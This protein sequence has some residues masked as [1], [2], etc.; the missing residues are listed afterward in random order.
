[1][2]FGIIPIFCDILDNGN[3]SP[4]A[5]S[6]SITP[7]TKAL[8]VTHMWGMPCNMRAIWDILQNHPNVLLIEDCSHAHGA[9]IDGQLVGTF[10]DAAAWSLQGQKIIS[11]GEG[12]ITLTKNAELYYRQLIWGHY[13][14]RCKAEI[15]SDH[16]LSS[17][18]LTG[19]GAKN[20]AHPLAIA[21]AF[22]QLERLD[23]I[24]QFKALY[25]FQMASRL[26]SIPFLHAPSMVMLSESQIEPAWYALVFRF[27]ASRAPNGLSRESFVRKL[28]ERGLCEVDIPKSTGLLHQEPLYTS[29]QKLFPHLYPHGIPPAYRRN[30]DFPAAQAFYDEAIKLPVW[31]SHSD[32]AVVNHYLDVIYDV[33]RVEISNSNEIN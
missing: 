21:L 33:A 16:P 8:V 22:T 9:K 17:F 12:G 3:I 28:H 26:A 32:Q 31:T 13:N 25:A 4:E 19:A 30:A 23:S 18:S 15:P 7:R 1:M 6:A 2:Q 24:I 20:R 5:I 29:P 10:G 14:K 11:G 27:I